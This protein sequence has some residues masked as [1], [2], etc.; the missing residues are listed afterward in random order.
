M[1]R[2]LRSS[3]DSIPQAEISEI[4]LPNAYETTVKPQIRVFLGRSFFMP[5]FALSKTGTSDLSFLGFAGSCLPGP[6]FGIPLA[7]F[8]LLI[9]HPPP[10]SYLFV[11]LFSIHPLIDEKSGCY[12]LLLHSMYLIP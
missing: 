12:N 7:P 3:L 10:D 2:S 6:S 9:F 11:V 1:P 5:P 4:W 8:F